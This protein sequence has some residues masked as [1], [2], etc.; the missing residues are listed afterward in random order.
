MK[1][2]VNWETLKRLTIQAVDD[3][4]KGKKFVNTRHLREFVERNPEKYP[5]LGSIA[6]QRRA[7]IY[8]SITRLGWERYTSHGSNQSVFID[9]RCGE[10]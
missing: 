2:L 10:R 8:G 4:Y 6:S 5:D 9:P 1:P 3:C 7:R